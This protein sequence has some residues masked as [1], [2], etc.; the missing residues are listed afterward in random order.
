MVFTGIFGENGGFDHFGCFLVCCV[1][2][3]LIVVVILA[4]LFVPIYIKAGVNRTRRPHVRTHYS[5]HILVTRELQAHVIIS[6]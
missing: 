4:W 1:F 5:L 2:Q 6:F 3:A